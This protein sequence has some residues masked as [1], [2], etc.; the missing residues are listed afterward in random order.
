M[1]GHDDTQ[2]RHRRDTSRQGMPKWGG[3]VARGWEQADDLLLTAYR[4]LKPDDPG[5]EEPFESRFRCIYRPFVT[6]M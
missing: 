1:K 6:A 3:G 2:D 5:G 4:D